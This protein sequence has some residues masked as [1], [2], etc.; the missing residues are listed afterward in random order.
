MAYPS[1]VT[2]YTNPNP[3]DK[4]NSPSHSAIETA[5]NIGLTELQ[6]FVGTL[7]S[8]AGTLMYDIRAAAS[9]GGGHVQSAAKGG[10]GQT[11]YSQGDILAANQFGTLSKLSIGSDTQA[12]TVDTT[13]PTK[14]KWSGVALP[15]NIQNQTYTYARASVYS[16]SVY[17]VNL[18][19]AVSI[20]SDGLG[21]QVK[22]PTTNTTSVL[23][24]SVNAQG[25]SSIAARIKNVDNTN[26]IVGAIQASMIGELVFDSVSSVFQ[27][28]N[29]YIPTYG[30]DTAKFL[31]N[32]GT[33]AFPGIKS[34]V[35]SSTLTVAATANETSILSYTLPGSTLGTNGLIRT[36]LLFSNFNGGGDSLT[37]RYNYGGASILSETFTPITNLVQTGHLEFNLYAQAVGTQ[38]ATV[39]RLVSSPAGSVM[40]GVSI[41]GRNADSDANQVLGITAKWSSNQ[42][43]LTVA[44]ISVEKV[45]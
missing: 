24:L 43:V 3:T 21:L 19:Q 26:P 8:V 10:T 39:Q 30:T 45:I 31:R 2:T 17:G 41:G 12:L 11:V 32:D 37:L 5:Q 18:S 16:A 35:F 9:D 33:W 22:F 28:Q 34:S 42:G 25:P 13:Q 23:A 36:K 40:T 15:V 27:L 1:V 44:G 20:L 7:S 38:F 4:L 29:T 6:T 14:L